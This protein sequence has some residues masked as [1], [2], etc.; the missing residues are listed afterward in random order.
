MRGRDGK[1]YRISSDGSGIEAV[2]STGGFILGLAFD[3]DQNLSDGMVMGDQSQ[4][5]EERM[6]SWREPAHKGD[7]P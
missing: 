5:S 6:V 3:G 7:A 2:A 4:S 1:I